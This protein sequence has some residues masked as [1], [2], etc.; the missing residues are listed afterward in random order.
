MTKPISPEL[1]GTKIGNSLD[2]TIR[3]ESNFSF[4]QKILVSFETD[5]T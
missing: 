4:G 5:F 3:S 2:S 1:A